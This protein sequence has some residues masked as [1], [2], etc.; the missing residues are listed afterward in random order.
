M[1]ELE[2]IEKVET[3]MIVLPSGDF[4]L[5][6]S[7]GDLADI[8]KEPDVEIVPPPVGLTRITSLRDQVEIRIGR[9]RVFFGDHSDRLPGTERFTEIICGL[10]SL[11]ENA[12]NVKYRAFGWN[13]SIAFGLSTDRLPSEVIAE[14]F[15]NRDEIR[16]KT[17]LDI[18]G[19]AVR[20]FHRKRSALCYLHLEPRG[21][22]IDADLYYAR[23]NV[24]FDISERLPAKEELDASFDHEYADFLNTIRAIL[25]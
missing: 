22:R 2:S 1:R 7:P 14:R 16:R 8:V 15:I 11:L 25:D 9:G 21:N 5:H 6:L 10:T 23:V 3:N 24:H 4:D 19:G 12:S 18:V 20:F 17:N 13:Y